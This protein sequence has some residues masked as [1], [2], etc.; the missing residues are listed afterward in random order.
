MSAWLVALVAFA[1]SCIV[2]ALQARFARSLL[3]DVPGTRS[4]HHLPTPTA[5]GI[6]VLTG[7]A[8]GTL[9]LPP[10]APDWWLALVLALALGIVGL[11]DDMRALPVWPRLLVQF[12]A[13][14]LLLGTLLPPAAGLLQLLCAAMA[15]LALAWLV[16]AF[17][18]MDGLDGF[19][20]THAL[21]MVLA[22]AML[23]P[24]SGHGAESR[25]VLACGGAAIAGFLVW[26]LPP[27]RLFMG[28][29]GS[30]A[31]GFLLAAAAVVTVHRGELSLAAWSILWAPLL[32]DTG[33]TLARRARRRERLHAAHRDHAYQR[34][35]RRWS[36]HGRVTLALV[37]I[38]FLWL[39]PLAWLSAR[40]PG[41]AGPIAALAYAPLLVCVQRVLRHVP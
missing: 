3:L 10:L 27:A 14:G 28:D 21:F 24:E 18:F 1:L 20:A 26:N 33:L 35:A 6:A 5:G 25:A 39:L 23:L 36:S 34:L 8:A 16:N 22:A 7:L 13:A 37:G 12:L 17:N 9:L 29:T 40:Y 38:D 2:A 31:L 4:S 32:V 19:A 41:Q 30:L 15:V 11:A